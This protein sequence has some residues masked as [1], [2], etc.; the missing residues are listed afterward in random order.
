MTRQDRRPR[1]G[2]RGVRKLGQPGNSLFFVGKVSGQG[3]KY[4]E[5]GEDR[6]AKARKMSKATRG[7]FKHQVGT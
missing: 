7:V 2:R 5:R 6:W 1:T 4:K 3:R